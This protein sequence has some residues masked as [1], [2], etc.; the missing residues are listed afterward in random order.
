MSIGHGRI[1]RGTR[2]LRR[3]PETVAQHEMGRLPNLDLI[4]FDPP[5]DPGL[6]ADQLFPGIVIKTSPPRIEIHENVVLVPD[7]GLLSATGQTLPAGQIRRFTNRLVKAGSEHI[8]PVEHPVT[9]DGEAIYMGRLLSHF[10]HFLTESMARWWAVQMLPPE[11]PLLFNQHLKGVQPHHFAVRFKAMGI[12]PARVIIP[13]EPTRFRRLVVPEHLF[14]ISS[15]AHESTAMAF[16]LA[17]DR[18][19]VDIE[20]TD[21]PLYLS[22]SQLAPKKRHMTRETLLDEFLR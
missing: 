14:E 3:A 16:Q 2:R 13:D 1:P 11:L 4:R 10:G 20:L 22:R 18:L 17:A 12:D 5:F 15:F 21:Q 6:T 19:C 8:D 9:F 7:E